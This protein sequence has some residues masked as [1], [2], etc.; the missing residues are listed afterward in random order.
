[1]SVIN[2]L[3]T[4]ISE[5]GHTGVC[6]GYAILEILV[7]A[8]STTGGPD[9]HA[10]SPDLGELTMR[11]RANR[12]EWLLQ[13][14]LEMQALINEADFNVDRFMQEVVDLVERVTEARG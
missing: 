11:S 7:L 4:G 5:I 8:T 2:G 14:V 13:R 6:G 12:L 9:M 10:V 1:M 3:P